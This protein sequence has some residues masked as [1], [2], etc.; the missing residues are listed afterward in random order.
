[1]SRKELENQMGSL[2]EKHQQDAAS[3]KSQLSEAESQAKDVQKEV[4]WNTFCFEG[5]QC[6]V[7]FLLFHYKSLNVKNSKFLVAELLFQVR[8][9]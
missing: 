6:P 7:T 3:L 5:I 2:R 1:M 8:L 9:C 4:T